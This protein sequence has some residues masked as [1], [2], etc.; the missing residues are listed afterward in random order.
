VADKDIFKERKKGLEEEYIAKHEAKLL[1]KLRERARLDKI[2]EAL[3]VHLQVSD[4]ALLKRIT[5]LG[6]TLE[7]APAFLLAPLVQIAW[8]EGSVT[9]RERD[10]VLRVA[11]ERGMEETSAAYAQLQQWLRQRPSDELFDANIEAIK[12]GLAVLDPHERA[13]RLTRIGEDCRRV[14][15]ASGGG[16]GRVLGLASGASPEEESLL[17]AIA[18]KLRAPR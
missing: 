2:A 13:D 8:A 7:T 4:P 18:A 15:E 9:D 16:L 5:D 10:T 12:A 17:D 3:A 14:A 11:V 1:E 6:V